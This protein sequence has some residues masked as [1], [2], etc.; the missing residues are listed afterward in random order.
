[1]LEQAPVVVT[2]NMDST[3]PERVGIPVARMVEPP[4]VKTF[5][6]GAKCHQTFQ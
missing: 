5:V 3:Y 4:T 6:P 2:L 1:M